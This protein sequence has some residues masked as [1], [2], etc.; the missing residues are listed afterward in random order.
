[1][2][3]QKHPQTYLVHL[4]TFRERERLPDEPPQALTHDVVEALNVA[5]LAFA[6]ARRLMLL[7]RQHLLVS[8]P[9]VAIK[10]S[11]FVRLGDAFPQQGAR[12]LAAVANDKSDDLPCSSALGQPNPAFVLAP[13]DK[14]PHLI[15]FEN[16]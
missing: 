8:L 10:E 13:I 15:E 5:G 9:E 1:M 7:V 11:F 14:R 12:F 16:V 2:L 6:F 4:V 3:V